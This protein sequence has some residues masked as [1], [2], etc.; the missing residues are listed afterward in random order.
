MVLHPAD[1]VLLR[2]QLGQLLMVLEE[3]RRR[4]GD[5]DR[6]TE[7]K[8]LESDRVVSR[9]GGEDDD[10]TGSGESGEGGLV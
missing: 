5:E 3:L 1:Q 7:G 4:L 2:R 9:V 8:R 6:V 10:E